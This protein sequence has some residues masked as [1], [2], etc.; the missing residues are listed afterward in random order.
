MIERPRDTKELIV[1]VEPIPL[2]EVETIWTREVNGGL[3]ALA[4]FGG[5]VGT[6][7]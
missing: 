2:A 1:G 5:I 7:G 4:V 6:V 3:T